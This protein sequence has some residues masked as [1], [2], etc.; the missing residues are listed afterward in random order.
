MAV[1]RYA[2]R[3]V[4]D[5]LLLLMVACRVA[6]EEWTV[7]E[8]CRLVETAAND[9]DSFE[10]RSVEPFRGKTENRFR[11][12]FVDAA[13]TDRN[14][15]FK[16]ERLRE[17]AAYWGSDD[18]DFAL[19]TGLRAEQFVR[20]LL[21]GR[22]TVYTKGDYAPSLGE[23][24]CY[25]LVRIGDRWLDDILAEQGLVRIY[26]QG[27][28]LPDGRSEQM[29][30][31]RLHQMERA[32]RSQRLNGWG[33]SVENKPAAEEDEM[34]QPHDAL[35]SRITWIYSVKN[36]RKVTVL[37]AGSTVSV[38]EKTDNGRSRIRFKKDDRVYEGLCET[39]CLRPE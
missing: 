31:N 27:T 13:E 26:G 7:L 2:S 3:M 9:A 20:R 35:T 18:P 21:R 6:A 5:G 30:W 14:S 25:A 22:F 37:P 16:R 36:G 1:K 32:A 33:R 17:Q 29:H 4:R 23:P 12:Y 11:L 39:A 15:E 38:M 28:D 10:V 24:R 34:F 19:Q 8:N